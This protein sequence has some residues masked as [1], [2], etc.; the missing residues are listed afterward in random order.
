[1][2]DSISFSPTP[3]IFGLL[4]VCLL[5]RAGFY[6]LSRV[7][8][9]RNQNCSRMEAAEGRAGGCLAHCLKMILTDR[10]GAA[11]NH[12]LD[13]S[14][15]FFSGPEGT[16]NPQNSLGSSNIQKCTPSGL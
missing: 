11:R 3:F 8:L 6:A 12:F 1:M 9:P 15:V 10:S 4:R 13:S 5:T 16:P 7:S 2:D 14:F